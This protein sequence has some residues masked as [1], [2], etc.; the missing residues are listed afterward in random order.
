MSELPVIRQ[1]KAENLSPPN[2]TALVASKLRN[3]QKSKGA[4]T[5]I[6]ERLAL[7]GKDVL[8]QFTRS[9]EEGSVEGYVLA[10]GPRFFLLALVEDN[11]RFNGFQC[12]RLQDVRNLQVPAKHARFIKAALK[13]RGE[14][15]P[16][17][18]SVVVDS[19][20]EILRTAGRAFP[21]ITI[22]RET[23]TP[24]VCHI[25]RVATVSD[26]QVSLLEIGPDADWDDET[27]SY[28]TREITRVDFGG[29]YEEALWQVGGPPV[30]H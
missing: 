24:E 6:R 19:V 8:V 30:N 27:T 16:R 11:A 4:A 3:M 18:P 26:S 17:L 23:V 15:R 12:L 2:Q 21:L 14:R 10:T 28:R 5:S 22:H 9:V 29:I 13:V 25:G 7:A 1:L 20:Q